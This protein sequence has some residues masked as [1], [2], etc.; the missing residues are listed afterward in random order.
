M[1]H[2]D[3]MQKTKKIGDQLTDVIV[4]KLLNDKEMDLQERIDL[5][6]LLIQLIEIMDCF[7]GTELDG[8]NK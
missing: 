5:I 3:W 8:D 6:L 4:G 2:C 1:F 7:E